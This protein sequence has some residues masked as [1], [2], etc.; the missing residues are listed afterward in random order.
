MPSDYKINWLN[1]LLTVILSMAITVVISIFVVFI[2]SLI[3]PSQEYSAYQSF[4]N[5]SGPWVAGIAGGFLMFWFSRR[6][7]QKYKTA[8]IGYSIALP[9]TYLIIDFLI[10]LL[11]GVV[12]SAYWWVLLLA[13]APK[14]AGSWFGRLSAIK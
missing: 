1:V 13:H 8:D 14:F 11:M 4:A 5:K 6:H 12:W 3:Y 2:Y 9:A 10:L 7:Y